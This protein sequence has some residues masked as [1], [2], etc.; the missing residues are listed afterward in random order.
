MIYDENYEKEAVIFIDGMEYVV[1]RIDVHHFSMSDPK[2]PGYQ[3]I[4]HIGQLHYDCP[5]RQEITEWLRDDSIDI[6]LREYHW[7]K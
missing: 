5:Y 1:K 2:R 7:E 4:W 3:V 6:S